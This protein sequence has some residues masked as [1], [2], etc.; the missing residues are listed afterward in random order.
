MNLQIIPIAI[1]YLKESFNKQFE[2]NGQVTKCCCWLCK[3]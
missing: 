3:L 1:S 2:S